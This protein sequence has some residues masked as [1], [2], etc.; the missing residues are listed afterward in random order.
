ML[1]IYE[2]I[3]EL[4]ES[5]KLSGFTATPEGHY[6][7]EKVKRLESEAARKFGVSHAIAFNSATS[8]LHAACE[9]AKNIVNKVDMK[10]AVTPFSFTASASCVLMVNR[11]PVFVDIEDKTY[12]MNPELIPDDV[13][14]VI[15]VHLF[16][17]PADMDTIMAKGKF[18]IEDA[19]QAMGAKYK[20]KWCGTIGDCGVFSFNQNKQIS[21]GEGGMLIT[22]NEDVADIARLVRNHGEVIDPGMWTLGY[23]YRM[24]EIEATIAYYRFLK[25]DEILN[26]RRLGT[27]MV[28]GRFGKQRT[29]ELEDHGAYVYPVR[30]KDNKK[31][32]E[33]MTQKGFPLRA[34]YLTRPLHKVPIYG[35]GDCPVT[36][37]MWSKELIVTDI[38]KQPFDD[39]QRFCYELEDVLHGD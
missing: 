23:N 29:C 18:V 15:P 32:A 4:I 19:A 14:V 35:G 31:V 37:K 11:I 3:K 12:C 17:H 8:A 26:H 24:T 2:E 9:A 30:V 34:G 36:D 13:D 28:E 27:L 33:A 39:I 20:G 21:C 38:I 6:G 1:G 16:G 5:D 7:G 10:Y 25:M 22:N